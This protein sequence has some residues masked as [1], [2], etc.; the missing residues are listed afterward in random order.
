[1]NARDARAR[2]I[3][4]G[5]T[6]FWSRSR[7]ELWHKGATS[8]N[9]QRVAGRLDCDG[10]A[11]LALVDQTGVRLPHR[12]AHL[13]LQRSRRRRRRAARRCCRL[14]RVIAERAEA[15]DPEASYTARCS[16]ASPRSARR[17]VRRP[18]RSR[19]RP[20][21]PRRRVV[22]ESADVLYHLAV[23]WRSRGA[24]SR[25]SPPSASRRRD[26]PAAHRPHP[27]AVAEMSVKPTLDEV[28][29]GGRPGS[30]RSSHTFIDDCETPV[31]AFL[32][33]RDGGPRVPARVG[34]AGAARR[35]LLVHRHSPA[36]VVAG[37]GDQLA[38]R[39][40]RRAIRT[41]TPSTRSGPSRTWSRRSAGAADREPRRSPAARSA[42]SATTWC[43]RSS[44]CRTSRPDD[45]RPA[46]H[47]A[48]AH[49]CWSCSS[50][51]CATR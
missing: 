9:V 33:L 15:A 16:K 46:G 38:V 32:K 40:A 25:R 50:T 23:L 13:L 37:V 18:R 1:M 6:W 29:A 45:R 11:L 41:S 3:E 8:G 44:A 24:T 27:P 42:S 12:R 31:S 20:R 48:D 19:A 2:T 36:A 17:W 47:G 10:D 39:S 5:Q 34:R 51:T 28:R 43:A 21:G 35:A 22:D 30:S 49:R 14:A 4:R 7:Q 26:E